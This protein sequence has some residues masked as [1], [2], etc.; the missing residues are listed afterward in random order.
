MAE[1]H[2]VTSNGL[3]LA[4]RLSGDPS[5]PCLILLHGWPQ[6]SLAWESA[7]D[8]LGKDHFALAFDLP[9]VGGSRGAPALSEKTCSA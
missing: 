3:S 2:N 7:L 4:Y 1:I 9:D 5:K 8:E 6:T